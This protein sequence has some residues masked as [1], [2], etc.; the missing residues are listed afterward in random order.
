MNALPPTPPEPPARRSPSAPGPNWAV[1]SA[2]AAQ[3]L[4]LVIDMGMARLAAVQAHGLGS[5]AIVIIGQVLQARA[6]L[7][8]AKRRVT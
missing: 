3:G 1:L 4:T 6:A 2:A 8:V 5:P 7:A